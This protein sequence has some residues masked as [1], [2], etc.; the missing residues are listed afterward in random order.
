MFDMVTETLL[1]SDPTTWQKAPRKI[2]LPLAWAE[3]RDTGPFHSSP[4]VQGAKLEGL[5]YERRFGRYLKKA[6][7]R[8]AEILS[9]QWFEFEDHGGPG[10]A[11]PDHILIYPGQ[12]LVFECKLTQHPHA[13]VQLEELYFP[14][15][16]HTWPEYD[17]RLV[18][19]FRSMVERP[20]HGEREVHSLAN[21]RDSECPWRTL[22]WHWLGS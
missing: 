13:R 17:V 6:A 7:R 18:E 14:L 4:R 3:M 5:R 19:V 21:I 11:Q 12:V 16:E 15:V 9:G 2:D 8:S 10:W 1:R 22:V 20:R